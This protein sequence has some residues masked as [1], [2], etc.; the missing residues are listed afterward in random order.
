MVTVRSAQHCIVIVAVVVTSAAI[1]S[2]FAMAAHALNAAGFTT[3]VTP[4]EVQDGS[5]PK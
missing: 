5:P 3:R 2:I 4:Q 1:I